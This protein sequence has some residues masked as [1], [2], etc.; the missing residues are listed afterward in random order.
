MFVSRYCFYLQEIETDE[1]ASKPSDSSALSADDIDKLIP[2]LE[3]LIAK[4]IKSSKGEITPSVIY[5]HFVTYVIPPSTL[6]FRDM[7]YSCELDVGSY[8]F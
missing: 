7:W 3:D 5:S 6:H 4:G 1:T 2:D 8:D